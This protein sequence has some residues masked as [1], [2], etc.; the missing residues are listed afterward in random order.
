MTGLSDDE[1]R[2]RYHGLLSKAQRLLEI[3]GWSDAARRDAEVYR[4][5]DCDGLTPLLALFSEATL[6][7]GAESIAFA[8]AE[9]QALEGQLPLRLEDRR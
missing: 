2:L 1:N 5:V 4:L 6:A 7:K 3:A 9:H 8:R